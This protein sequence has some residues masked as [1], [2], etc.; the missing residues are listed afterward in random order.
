[1][2]R[3]CAFTLST[4]LAWV[5]HVCTGT[6]PPQASTLLASVWFVRRYPDRAWANTLVVVELRDE[7]PA[8]HLSA[9]L[10]GVNRCTHSDHIRVRI[11]VD[12]DQGHALA[13]LGSQL[14]VAGA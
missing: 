1:M 7:L 5:G 11:R 6:C 13:A 12:T 14:G 3:V 8:T 10:H 4:A 2:E 9:L